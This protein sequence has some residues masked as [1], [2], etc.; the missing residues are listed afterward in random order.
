MKP[1][2]QTPLIPHHT[3]S[4]SHGS[5]L[6]PHPRSGRR[7]STSPIICSCCNLGLEST[8]CP[9]RKQIWFLV[10]IRFVWVS[11]IL[12][13]KLQEEGRVGV[14]K[15]MGNNQVSK[16]NDNFQKNLIGCGLGLFSP[17][18]S[19]SSPPPPP[20][21]LLFLFFFSFFFFFFLAGGGD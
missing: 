14:E 1:H 2:F 4:I 11:W 10:F 5:L 7:A 8:K 13:D 20:P 12:A 6:A 19:F 18:P 15:Q 3:S 21:F 17:P 9:F 16:I